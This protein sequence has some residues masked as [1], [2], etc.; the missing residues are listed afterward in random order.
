[1]NIAQIIEAIEALKPECDAHFLTHFQE[2]K[3]S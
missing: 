3:E 2:G 1:M